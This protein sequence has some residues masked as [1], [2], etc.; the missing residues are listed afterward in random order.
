MD[1]TIPGVSN[2]AGAYAVNRRIGPRTGQER[3]RK[4]QRVGSENRS[5]GGRLA[6]QARMRGFRIIDS[7]L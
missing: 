7:K 5:L 4:G 6:A 2:P 3:H 1:L